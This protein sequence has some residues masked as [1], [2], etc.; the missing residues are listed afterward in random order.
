MADVITL[1]EIDEVKNIVAENQANLNNLLTINTSH[2]VLEYATAGSRTWTCPT[3]VSMVYV[4]AAGGG[5]GGGGGG[6][7]LYRSFTYDYYWKPTGG[8]SGGVGGVYYC[9]IP[10]TAGTNYTIVTGAGGTAGAGGV[11]GEGTVFEYAVDY[12]TYEGHKANNGGNGG[13]GGATKFG[14]L[15]SVGGGKGGE[16]GSGGVGADHSSALDEKPNAGGA[17]GGNGSTSYDTY[18]N[19]I[20]RISDYINGANGTECDSGAKENG[21]S[22]TTTTLSGGAKKT[23][24][25]GLSSG[26]G[27][28]G[29]KNGYA[30]TGNSTSN[31]SAGTD[32]SAGSTGSAGYIKI[33][34]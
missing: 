4:V 33:C 26:A 15:L 18:K 8:G 20:F 9:I 7:G 29:G 10:V 12:P 23:S 17:G 5:G 19:I 16:G 21:Y 31:G 3:G 14:T 11:K 25:I 34:W 1:N 32:G 27:G 30:G 24:T 22:N 6:A 28:A 13:D 2:G